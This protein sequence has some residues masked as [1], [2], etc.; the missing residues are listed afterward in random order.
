MNKIIIGL[1]VI[2]AIAAGWFILNPGD[3]FDYVV[4]VDSEITELENELAALDAQVTAGTLTEEQATAAKVKI[5]TRLNT[6]NEASTNSEKAQL[7]AAQRAQLIA[8]LDRL[9]VILVTYQ[10]TFATV[11][12][13]ANEAEV[14]RQ[15]NKGGSSSSKKLGLIVADT[16]TDVE[17]TVSDTIPEYE[18]NTALDA[19]VDAAI[20]ETE[21]DNT[22]EE[23]MD[24]GQM[25][26]DEG[27]MEN[28]ETMDDDGSM[29]SDEETTD[30]DTATSD[31]TMDDEAM[32]D[33]EASADV[34]LETTTTN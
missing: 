29:D 11:D 27:M 22:G 32:L 1:I 30:D 24:D 17:D 14:N 34:E 2:V 8:G 20:E 15:L 33:M 16:I 12:A 28:E 26:D 18:A 25:M 31:E 7:T 5:V 10:D 9:K 4:T 23:A 19:E 6:I 13:T 21:S 3:T